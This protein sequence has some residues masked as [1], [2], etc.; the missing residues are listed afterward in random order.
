[1]DHQQHR[2]AH[3]ASPK[4]VDASGQIGQVQTNKCSRMGAAIHFGTQQNTYV[5]TY[6]LLSS[7]SPKKEWVSIS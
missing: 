1:M 7:Y 3:R 6:I 5:N 4:S 2:L